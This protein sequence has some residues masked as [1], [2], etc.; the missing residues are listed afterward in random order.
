MARLAHALESRDKPASG[1]NRTE[2]TRSVW[3][4]RVVIFLELGIPQILQSPLHPEVANN[5][6]SGLKQPLET[7]RSSAY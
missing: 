4:L 5:V 7:H 2:I 3:P 1:W 6:S